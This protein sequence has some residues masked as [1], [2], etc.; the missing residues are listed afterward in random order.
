MV[1]AMY[2]TREQV[3]TALDIQETARSN[4]Q[5]DRAIR[6]SS[7]SIEGQLRRRFY[8]EIRTQYFEWPVRGSRTTWR[9]RLNEHELISASAVVSGGV[10][11]SASDYFL[12]PNDGPPYDTIEIDRASTSAFS[13]NAGTNQRSVAI[14]GTFGHSSELE[15]VGALSSNLDADAADSPA[16]TWSAPLDVGIG[17]ILKIDSEYL[18]VTNRTF[19]DST[20][21]ALDPLTAS[22]ANVTVPV[23]TGSDFYSGEILLIDSEKMR[24]VDVV[25]NNLFVQRAVDG[26]AL[27]A[28]LDNADIYV[29]SGVVT[30]RAQFG[31]TLAAHLSAANV[32]RHVIPALVNDLAIAEALTQLNQE[33]A[34]YG[35]VV[36]SGENARE[37]SGKGLADLRA[38]AYDEF[39]RKARMRSV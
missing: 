7:R 39:G 22:N 31:S 21:D 3:K 35:R 38:R 5:I 9:L 12:E 18:V 13:A 8:P 36:G 26:T 37:A 6:S 15:V 23:T 16:V 19:A 11:I 27:A 28:H 1:Q 32:E 29:L 25:G 17:S 33:S 24:V 4:S 20:Q 30:S 2:A 10:T 34:G 14:S